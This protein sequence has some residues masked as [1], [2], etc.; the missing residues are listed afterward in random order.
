MHGDVRAGAHG[1]ADVGSGQR[2]SV[3]D[4]VSSHRDN[5]AFK[6]QPF[7]HFALI[8][9]AET[10]AFDLHRSRAWHGD[11]VGR[12]GVVARQHHDADACR[13]ERGDRLLLT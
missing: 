4:P 2:R 12:G 7:D 6:A 9:L 10:S 8:G 3:V 1:N 11:R 5:P 13:F